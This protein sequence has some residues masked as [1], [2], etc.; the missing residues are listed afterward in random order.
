VH[1]CN[2]VRVFGGGGGVLGEQQEAV[3]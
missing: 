1:P 3:I 2:M